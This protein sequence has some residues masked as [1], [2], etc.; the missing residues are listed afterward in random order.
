MSVLTVSV[1]DNLPHDKV[2]TC[3]QTGVPLQANLIE[4]KESGELQE[5]FAPLKDPLLQNLIDTCPSY[6]P[7]TGYR[8]V[9]TIGAQM[10]KRLFEIRPNASVVLADFDYLPP[11]DIMS[12]ASQR[13]ITKRADGE[14]LGKLHLV[15]LMK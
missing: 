8:W 9:P 15:L 7:P 3:R 5:K 6:L 11:P 10:L 12:T 1:Q 13:K 4:D 14:P 2:T